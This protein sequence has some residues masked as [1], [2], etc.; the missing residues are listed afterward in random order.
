MTKWY[1][2][3]LLITN[4]GVV[5]IDWRGIFDKSSTRI[6]YGTIIGVSYEK[7]GAAQTLFDYG[8]LVIEIEHS[9]ERQVALPNAASPLEAEEK[10]LTLKEKFIQ[11]HSLEN[12]HALKE[13]LSE[14]V[15]HHVAKKNH[16]EGLTDML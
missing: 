7:S 2:D 10:I 12:E 11:K 8:P 16:S 6:D 13:I 3:V 15:A 4:Y 5:D 9:G 14:M 1:F